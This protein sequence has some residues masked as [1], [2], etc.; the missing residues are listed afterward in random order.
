MSKELTELLRKEVQADVE[1]CAC[2]G[3]GWRFPNG[4]QMPCP[5]CADKRALLKELCWHAWD[6]EIKHHFLTC[7]ICGFEVPGYHSFK[8][9]KETFMIMRSYKSSEINPDLTTA[10]SGSRLLVV[11]W[12]ERAGLWGEFIMWHDGQTA[13]ILYDGDATKH[14]WETG[15]IGYVSDFD[16]AALAEILTNGE[17]LCQA[18]TAWL[19]EG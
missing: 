11:E 10:M 13:Y 1:G 18:I 9:G 7:K 6:G 8:S 2:G 12:M 19:K 14:T 5:T 3:S 15:G 17:L 16:M 4:V